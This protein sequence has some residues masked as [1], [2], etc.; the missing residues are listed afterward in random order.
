MASDS[1]GR[2]SYRH[3][4]PTHCA[5]SRNLRSGHR[6]GTKHSVACDTCHSRKSE[7]RVSPEVRIIRSTGGHSCVGRGHMG[8]NVLRA[9]DHHRDMSN[10]SRAVPVVVIS[11]CQCMVARWLV[12]RK[13]VWVLPTY[14]HQSYSSDML[15]G[16]WS[17]RQAKADCLLHYIFESR[18]P[19]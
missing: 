15:G 1:Q 5:K 7:S 16:H 10:A 18:P 6:V 9:L 17:L 19:H 3:P 12:V 13:T 11:T 8:H 2:C 4:P 14:D